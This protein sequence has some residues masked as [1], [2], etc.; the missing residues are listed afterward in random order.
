MDGILVGGGID[1]ALVAMPAWHH[2]GPVGWGTFSRYADLG[3]G[4]VLYP[5]EAFSGMILSVAAAILFRAQSTAPRAARM[6]IYAAAL[7]TVGGLRHP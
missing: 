5:L 4:L 3:N 7:F 1:R 6:P 2:V